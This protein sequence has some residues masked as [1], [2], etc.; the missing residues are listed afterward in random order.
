MSKELREL[1]YKEG[2]ESLSATEIAE[3]ISL[4]TQTSRPQDEPQLINDLIIPYHQIYSGGE[5]FKISSQEELRKALTS[6]LSPLQ[7]DKPYIE[8]ELDPE[9]QY[10]V[11][12]QI[13]LN[14]DDQAFQESGLKSDLFLYLVCSNLEQAYKVLIQ[15]EKK[16]ERKKTKQLQTYFQDSLFLFQMQPEI[17]DLVSDQ[18]ILKLWKNDKSNSTIFIRAV[19]LKEETA[20]DLANIE[21]DQLEEKG[22]EELAA[23]IIFLRLLKEDFDFW[24]KAYHS[25]RTYLGI[26]AQEALIEA[27]VSTDFD[28]EQPAFLDLVADLNS[29]VFFKTI[30]SLISHNRLKP[31]STLYKLALKKLAECRKVINLGESRPNLTSRI[32]PAVFINYVDQYDP[33]LTADY[34]QFMV[35]LIET[36]SMSEDQVLFNEEIMFVE[37]L[38]IGLAPLIKRDMSKLDQL[39]HLNEVLQL[40]STFWG[41]LFI[42]LFPGNSD[43]DINDIYIIFSHSLV[44]SE[45]ALLKSVILA[46]RRK[47]YGEAIEKSSFDS[48][49]RFIL[50]KLSMYPSIYVNNE[51]QYFLRMSA[52]LLDFSKLTRA[53][54]P[55]LANLDYSLEQRPV[56]NCY[57]PE[58]LTGDVAQVQQVLENLEKMQTGRQNYDHLTQINNP[59][60]TNVSDNEFWA[61]AQIQFVNLFKICPNIIDI[62]FDTNLIEN[63]D[64]SQLENLLDDLNQIALLTQDRNITRLF[65]LLCQEFDSNRLLNFLKQ[66]Y[67]LE[68]TLT[69]DK[70]KELRSF[71]EQNHNLNKQTL[72][73]YLESKDVSIIQCLEPSRFE[74]LINDIDQDTASRLVTNDKIYSLPFLY[75]SRLHAH[76]YKVL[77]VNQLDLFIENLLNKYITSF[78]EDPDSVNDR[79][80]EEALL[81]ANIFYE[82]FLVNLLTGLDVNSREIQSLINDFYTSESQK[83]DPIPEWTRKTNALERNIIGLLNFLGAASKDPYLSDL[84]P[85][86]QVDLALTSGIR[87]FG[88]HDPDIIINNI[89]AYHGSELDTQKLKGRQAAVMFKALNDHNGALNIPEKELDLVSRVRRVTPDLDVI[90]IDA[91]WRDFNR[92]LVIQR[93]RRHSNGKIYTD[94]QPWIKTLILNQ[95]GSPA[96]ITVGSM[97]SERKYITLEDIKQWQKNPDWDLLPRAN[98]ILISCSTAQINSKV[99][100]PVADKL[101]ERVHRSVIGP[102]LPTNIDRWI[103]TKDTDSI[104]IRPIYSPD[105]QRTVVYGA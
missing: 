63:E 67:D 10:E 1:N 90:I 37:E 33:D 83:D 75:L 43:T 12:S 91:S 25:N 78:K 41:R 11:Y 40:S 89:F 69:T 98:L 85:S 44:G 97:H 53:V 59:S 58:I 22:Y 61:K 42:R 3:I 62:V 47:N 19:E 54:S 64:Y 92:H 66:K 9:Q 17:I 21:F 7:L 84:E 50:K 68:S 6:Y 32:H 5:K 101:T 56:L 14:T 57:L 13:I 16:V 15:L 95:H 105:H 26:M 103:V 38:I 24:I 8:I 96:S 51:T 35:S 36:V 23:D 72:E 81:Q 48:F 65:F 79:S 39:A 28:L 2:R 99:L 80:P 100:Q 94:P 20:L 30:S 4:T 55:Q 77:K 70:L 76:F 31:D 88:R 74:D 93:R 18:H 104:M 86:R 29:D 102:E 46:Y 87:I 73:G 27:V 60:S 82:N 45:Q 52:R 34:W 49:Y 71:L